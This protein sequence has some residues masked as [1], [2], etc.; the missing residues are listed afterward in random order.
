MSYCAVFY[1][2]DLPPAL[3]LLDDERQD[4]GVSLNKKRGINKGWQARGSH[5]GLAL[6]LLVFFVFGF[7]SRAGFK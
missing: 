4:I 5:F 2:C 3:R 7:F 1:C 6:G